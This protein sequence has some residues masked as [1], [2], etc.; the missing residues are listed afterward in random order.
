MQDNKEQIQ[1]SREQQCHPALQY[2]LL[3]SG[4]YD[5]N[6]WKQ[7]NANHLHFFS[8]LAIYQSVNYE[9]E[10]DKKYLPVKSVSL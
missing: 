9:N 6:Q 4:I 7:G 10:Q 3:C 5:Q 8:K 2:A 1:T